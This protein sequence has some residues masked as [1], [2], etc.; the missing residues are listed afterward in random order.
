MYVFSTFLS[1]RNSAL[2][3]MLGILFQAPD[4]PFIFQISYSWLFKYAFCFSYTYLRTAFCI[5]ALRIIS[6]WIIEML[7][8]QCLVCI[9]D[10]KA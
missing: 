9:L 10:V 2:S 3:F 7:Q 8:F 5:L 4:G 1:L 6:Y